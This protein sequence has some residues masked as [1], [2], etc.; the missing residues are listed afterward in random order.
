MRFPSGGGGGEVVLKCVWKT[1]SLF[2]TTCSYFGR[3][4]DRL[5]VMLATADVTAYDGRRADS[6]GIRDYRHAV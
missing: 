3:R 6:V 5:T 4:I 2:L 1:S